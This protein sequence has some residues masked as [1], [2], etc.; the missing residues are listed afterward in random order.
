MVAV[1]VSVLAAPILCDH[2]LVRVSS[3]RDRFLNAYCPCMC[4][5][6]STNAN[7]QPLLLFWGLLP[8]P[9][10]LGT[11]ILHR[12]LHVFLAEEEVPDALVHRP[13]D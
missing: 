4:V 6:P 10:S 8:T 11:T 5:D 1:D 2:L 13:W 7:V 3:L 9:E 12:R